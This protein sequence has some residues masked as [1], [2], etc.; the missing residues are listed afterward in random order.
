MLETSVVKQ[1]LF[2]YAISIT[3][4]AWFMFWIAYDIFVWHKPLLE[5]NITNYIGAAAS[6]AFIW[7]EAKFLKTKQSKKIPDPTGEPKP[8]K[9][10]EKYVQ[11]P[12]IQQNQT[13]P[14]A[15]SPSQESTNK[16]SC[17]HHIEYI[18]NQQNQ[19]QMP[20]ECLTCTNLIQCL[21]NEKQK[22]TKTNRKTTSTENSTNTSKT[23]RKKRNKK[24][25]TNQQPKPRPKTRKQKGPLLISGS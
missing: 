3:I 7:A 8:R 20:N 25:S 4:Y 17:V 1:Q 19:T 23:K 5:G 9:T 16:T 6:I 18:K 13:H 12:K 10:R 22:T 24:N 11:Q 15:T 2:W 14:T 21:N